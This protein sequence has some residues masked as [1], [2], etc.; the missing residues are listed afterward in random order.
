MLITL[1]KP[2]G[3]FRIGDEVSVS[4]PRADR[5]ATAGYWTPIVPGSPVDR[6]KLYSERL[7]RMGVAELKLHAKARFDTDLKAKTKPTLIKNI[8]KL[9]SESEG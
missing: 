5:M 3:G 8:L 7:D 2:W 9:N 1:E 6:E 4:K